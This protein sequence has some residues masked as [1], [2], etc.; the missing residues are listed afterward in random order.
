MKKETFINVTADCSSPNSTT[1]EI[2]AL[3]YMIAVMFSVLDQNEKKC[4]HLS[5]NRTCR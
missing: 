4:Y 2:E 3:K 1:G 5:I